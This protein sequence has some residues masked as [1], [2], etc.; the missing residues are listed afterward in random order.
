MKS[1]VPPED[2]VYQF[3]VPAAVA[4]RLTVPVPHLVPGVVVEI[5][6]LLTVIVT[7]FEYPGALP[8]QFVQITLNRYWVV[9]EMVPIAAERGLVW[10]AKGTQIAPLKY[11]H[12]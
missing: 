9:D 4:P 3:M 6:G 1:D 5:V 7:T 11:S 8:Q 10:P 2:A 12:W